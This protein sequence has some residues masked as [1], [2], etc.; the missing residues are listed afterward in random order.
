MEVRD[1]RLTIARTAPGARFVDNI[2]ADTEHLTI[3]FSQKEAGRKGE[4]MQQKGHPN[5]HR[6]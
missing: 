4:V 6:A 1:H 5:L 3:F 2:I